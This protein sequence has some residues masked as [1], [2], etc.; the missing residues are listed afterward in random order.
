LK[1]L[2]YD[3]GVPGKVFIPT[4]HTNAFHCL[5]QIYMLGDAN[6]KSH[7]FNILKGRE[8]WLTSKF[9]P[10]LAIHQSS[11]LA[12]DIVDSLDQAVQETADWLIAAGVD[13]NMIDINGNS[14]LHIASS[15]GMRSLVVALLSAG[16]DPNAVNREHRNPLHLAASHGHA[17]VVKFLKEAGGDMN[18]KDAHDVTPLMI[19]SMPGPVLAADAK[20]FLDIDQREPRKIDRDTHPETT[21]WADGGYSITFS[22]YRN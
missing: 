4:D 3:I 13:P 20:R 22:I 9:D 15:G 5:A 7:I 10:P 2:L 14:P 18:F 6:S 21:Y 12:R 11:V 19:I 8:S 17:E 16:A 1:Y